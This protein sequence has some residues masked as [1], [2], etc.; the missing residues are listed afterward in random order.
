MRYRVNTTW[1]VSGGS[2]LLA[3]G[4]IVGDTQPN[5]SFLGGVIPPP[6]CTPL[7]QATRDWLVSVYRQQHGHGVEIVP[8]PPTEI[9]QTNET[10]K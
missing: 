3:G 5:W 10:A 4:T 9:E 8:V 6:D 7:D 2:M 1:P